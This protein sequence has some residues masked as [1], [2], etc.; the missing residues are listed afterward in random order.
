MKSPATL[1]CLLSTASTTLPLP[2]KD[3]NAPEPAK[4]D[5][6]LPTKDTNAPEPAKTDLPLPTE[7]PYA[8]EPTKTAPTKQPRTA[9]PDS[10]AI[11]SLR[12]RS[13]FWGLDKRDPFDSTDDNIEREVLARDPQEDAE[14]SDVEDE[15]EVSWDDEEPSLEAEKRSEEE[16]SDVED[17]EEL[18]W[19]EF[20]E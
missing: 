15:E 11:R 1:L 6:P 9:E 5:L 3:T 10:D 20:D 14:E 16:E 17:E 4:T 19:E 2:T 12:N 7:D 13:P 18:P 8:P